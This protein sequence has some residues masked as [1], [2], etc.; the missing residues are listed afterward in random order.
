MIGIISLLAV[1]ILPAY[2]FG[3]DNPSKDMVEIKKGCLSAAIR[4]IKLEIKRN[5][6]WLQYADNDAKK[7][8]LNKRI[9]QLEADLTKYEARNIADYQLPDK[10]EMEAWFEVPLKDDAVLDFPGIS[11]SGPWYHLAGI[12]GEDYS[13]IKP[14]KKYLMT[15][16][17]V[18]PREYAWME[19]SYIYV[20]QIK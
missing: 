14:K 19:S 11:R 7:E 15:F 4:G 9:K 5:E 3:Q 20:D 6:R 12:R 2:S 18:Y 16:Y 13:I 1:L 17:L 10:K 8:L